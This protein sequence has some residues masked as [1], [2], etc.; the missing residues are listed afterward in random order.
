MRIPRISKKASS[1]APD[2]P[3]QHKNSFDFDEDIPDD[4]I[5]AIVGYLSM[6]ELLVLCLVVSATKHE[7]KDILTTCPSPGICTAFYLRLFIALSS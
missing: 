3:S 7:L 1:L 4:V 6:G 2:A 5:L